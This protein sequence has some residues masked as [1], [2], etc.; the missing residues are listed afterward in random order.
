MAHFSQQPRL[1]SID[2]PLG[3]DTLLLTRIEGE[4]AL[5]SLFSFEIEMYSTR[6]SILPAEIVGKNVTL[7]LMQADDQGLKTDSHTVINGFVRQFR[8]EGSQLQDLRCYSAEV[9]PWLWFLTQTSDSKVFQH[10]NIRQIASEVFADNGFSDFEFRLIGQ[11]PV[12]DYCVQYQESDFT[13]LSR[14]FE[15]EG[16]YYFFKHSQGQ[17]I[18]VLADHSSAPE[19]CEESS[20]TFRT[21]SLSA[22]TIH[23]WSHQHSFRTGR[24]AKRDYDFKKPS[25]VMQTGIK[26]DMDVAGIGRYEQFLY[27]GRYYNKGLGENLTR[28]RIEHDEAL[29]D[30]VLGKSTCRTF[31][32]GHTFDLSRHDDN[33]GE[34]DTYLLVS[35]QHDAAD[36]SYTSRDE[37][38]RHYENCFVCMPASR[39]YRPPLKT[40]WPKMLGPQHAMIV[41]PP[42]EEI[43]TDAFGRV[44]V[45]F[46]W[47]RYGKYNENS[48]CWVRV[49]HQWAGKNWGSIYI[50]RIGQ[51]VIVDFY[52][53]NPD[54]PIITGRVYNA[55]QMPPWNLPANKTQSG[56]LTRSSKGGSA[57]N[58]N[59]IR[60]EDLKGEE[61]LFIHAEKNQ[62]IEVENDETH[63]VGRDREKTIDRDETVVVKH[64]RTEDVGNN[65]TISIVKNRTETVG[66]NEK[67]SIAKNHTHSIGKTEIKSVGLARISAVGL[68][69]TL[70]V[71]GM[72]QSLV[73]LS[74]IQRVGI[75]DSLKVGQ[76]LSIE[77]GETIELVCGA[78]KIVLTPSAIHLDS[79]TI[80]IL[81]G[82]A[83]NIDGGS[84]NINCGAASGASPEGPDEPEEASLQ[85][86]DVLTAPNVP[87]SQPSPIVNTTFA[88]DSPS[89]ALNSSPFNPS[90]APINMTA[91][92]NF[93]APEGEDESGFGIRDGLSLGV[94]LT[95]VL[96]SAQSVVELV[97]GKDYI[98]GEETSRAWAAAGIIAG[99]IP[100]GKGALK[101]VQTALKGR[102]VAR[103][104]DD[105]AEAATE[106]G[107]VVTRNT[108]VV[109]A[110]SRGADEAGGSVTTVGQRVVP[111][112]RMGPNDGPQIPEWKGAVD[113]I[114]VKDP[115]NLVNTK[116]TPRQVRQMKELNRQQNDGFLRSDLDG[117]LMVDSKKSTR[118]VTPPTHEVQV[119]HKIP[120][121]KG[122]TRTNVNLQL[123]TRKQNRDKWEN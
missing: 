16:I 72:Q 12:R 123:L 121:A 20:V 42:G 59:C 74:R 25:D 67:I 36:Y 18:L 5:S 88:T 122:G 84:V 21:G 107:N 2:S 92:T 65:E 4:E 75:K 48:S 63:W 96:G 82:S 9:V 61:Q 23:S 101:G 71:G 98:T 108:D 19:T 95:P 86:M 13:F 68:N 105:V 91:E 111:N 110:S 33:P 116:P 93:V 53:G 51:E 115:K 31:R 78:S 3:Q 104:G 52:D 99:L 106:S 69:E 47:D 64:D 49:S 22:H 89:P 87:E 60:F 40:G 54:R 55:E 94:G 56:V 37:E 85:A 81:G 77:A 113:Y 10:K 35:I 44:K 24:Y 97:S 15:E 109:S 38:T 8:G 117:T 1:L 45:Q 39:V 83:V 102:R 32:T 27:P 114:S 73:G 11:H 28:L 7:K 66:G 80:H 76:T 119:D 30:Q 17:H 62:D 90:A 50:P 43:Y 6:Q 14:L 100:F 46:P 58:A 118:S 79:P 41:G 34:L 103:A 26:G 70:T 57:E 120:V 112:T 29:H